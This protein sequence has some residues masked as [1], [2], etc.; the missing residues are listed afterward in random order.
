MMQDR[1]ELM[2]IPL[3]KIIGAWDDFEP[4]GELHFHDIGT[5]FIKEISPVLRSTS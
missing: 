4:T 3:Q 5:V 1:I 2:E